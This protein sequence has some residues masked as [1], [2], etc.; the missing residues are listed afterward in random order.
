MFILTRKEKGLQEFSFT[1]NCQQES[2]IYRNLEKITAIKNEWKAPQPISSPS[3][4]VLFIPL[5]IYIY[6]FFL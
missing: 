5:Y 3:A 1:G 2:M 6:F 4:T